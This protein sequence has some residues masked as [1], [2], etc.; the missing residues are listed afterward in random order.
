MKHERDGEKEGEKQKSRIEK[1]TQPGG[2]NE[3]RITYSS[4]V[5]RRRKWTPGHIVSL[6]VYLVCVSPKRASR[7]SEPWLRK[8]TLSHKDGIS[9]FNFRKEVFTI[10]ISF[11]FPARSNEDHTQTPPPAHDYQLLNHNPS[12]FR[13]ANEVQWWTAMPVPAQ[14]PCEIPS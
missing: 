2:W 4:R 7:R 13:N 3:S 11:P 5:E 9:A 6:K 1:S 12:I 14:A 8:E 10:K